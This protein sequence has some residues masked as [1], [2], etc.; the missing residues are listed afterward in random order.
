MTDLNDDIAAAIAGLNSGAAPPSSAPMN[1][2]E[3]PPPAS[4]QTREDVASAITGRNPDGT[5]ASSRTAPEARDGAAAPAGTDTAT[6]PGDGQPAPAPAAPDASKDTSASAGPQ[7]FDPAKPPSGWTPEMKAKWDTLPEEAR[8]EITRREEASYLGFEKFRKQVE[9]AI[10]IAQHVGQ[11]EPYFKHIGVEAKPY[12]QNVIA[13]EQG[14]AL[15][16]P[17]QKFETL[18]KIGETYGVPMRQILDQ[19][20]GGKLDEIL[21]QGHTHHKTPAP[22]PPEV[23]QELQEARQWRQE[24]ADRQAA[25]ELQEL[26]TNA[27]EYPLLSEISDQMAD[28]IESGKADNFKDAYDWV[29]FK[30]PKLRERQAALRNGQAQQD[31]LRNRQAAAA[32]L[33]HPGSPPS[34]AA[35]PQEPESAEDAVRQAFAAHSR[36]GGV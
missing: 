25:A 33:T 29:V 12:L 11:F 7:V 3:A 4:P 26:K 2:G 18:I 8:K 15:G 32:N 14:L 5:F 24:Q 36:Q 20:L 31:A 17:T 6:P 16:N 1:G 27:A 21:R 10:D 13:M 22:L 23:Q 30:D 35:Q 28:A 34:R 9:P 19:A